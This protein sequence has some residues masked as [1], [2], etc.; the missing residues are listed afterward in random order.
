VTL[1][2]STIGPNVT[3][4]AG[5]SIEGSTIANSI[6]GKGVKVKDAQVKGSVVGDTQKIDKDLIDS[7]MD[8][9]E[10]ALAR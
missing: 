9:G 10:S 2:N 5:S 8:A 7:V 1:K 3:I 6:L 4:E